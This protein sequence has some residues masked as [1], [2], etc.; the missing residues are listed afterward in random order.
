LLGVNHVEGHIY[1]NWLTHERIEF[2]LIGL[3]VSGGHTVLLRMTGHGSYELLGR[4]R[5]DSA[6]EA[7]DKA[8]RVMGL[9][10]PGGPE[11]DRLASE[12][13]KDA[14]KLPMALLNDNGWDF[15]FSG[16]KTAVTRLVQQEKKKNTLNLPD[17]AASFQES[18][19][20][21]LTEKTIRAALRFETGNILIAGGVAANRELRA[22]MARRA[23]E[24]GLRFYCPDPIFC[25]DNAAMIA[26]VAYYRFAGGERSGWDLNAAPAMEL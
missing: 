20:E 7:F 15:S 26:C 21:V 9:P 12:G 16:L 5:D 1:A 2:P 11:I 25:T 10:Y 19:V 18:A 13:R 6:G 4:T 8:A 17:L 23:R 3:I 24:E 14:Y 22:R